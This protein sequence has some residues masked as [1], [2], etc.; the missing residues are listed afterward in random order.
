V[1]SFIATHTGWAINLALARMGEKASLDYCFGKIK[2]QPLSD[3]VVTWL[4]PDLVYTRQP[5]AINYI[6]SQILAD[7]KDCNSSSPETDEKTICAFKIIEMVAPVITNFPIKV[8]KY[9]ELEIDN[10]DEALLKI[11]NWV[12][13][14]PQI[15]ISNETY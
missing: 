2:S 11:R 7:S 14:K 5:E 13:S 6:L 12:L 8:D 15:L 1:Q 3:K 4:Y 10:Y 9:G